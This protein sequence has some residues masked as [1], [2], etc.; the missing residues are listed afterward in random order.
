MKG[1][2]VWRLSKTLARPV[3]VRP[4]ENEDVKFAWGAY[5]K[6]A[7][8]SMG[9][10][11]HLTAI[12]F[13]AAFEMYVLSEFQG[14][15]TVVAQTPKGTM[16]IGFMFGAWAPQRAFM[17]VCGIVWFPW[18]TKRNIVEGTVALFDTVRKQVNLMGF[19]SREHKPLYEV[20]MQHAI[21]RR[22]GTSNMG[23]EPIAVFET[24]R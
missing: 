13:K 20:C 9:F 1:K 14:A 16:P 23:D 22:I 21:M 24:R 19:A 10:A 7:L 5:N 6:G 2:K 12:Q 4:I 15:W 8:D 11:P 17:I 18:A 3:T